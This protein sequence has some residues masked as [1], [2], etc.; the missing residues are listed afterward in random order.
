MRAGVS[1]ACLYPRL[2]EEALYDLALGGV[3]HTEIFIN[4]DC[5]CNRAFVAGLAET[6]SRFEMTCRAVHP[7]TC[8]M[9]PMMFFSNYPRRMN[10]I[11]EYYKRFFG[12]M[13]QLGAQIFVFHGNKSGMQ[14]PNALYFERYA[15]LVQLGKSFGVTVAQENVSRCES[16]SLRFLK[17]MAAALGD[18]AHFV[19]DTKQAVRA[20]ENIFDMVRA[21]GDHICH[22]HISDHGE[23]G[24]CLPIGKGRFQVKR[25]L[26]LLSEV[27][28][29]GSVMLELYRSNFDTISELVHNY[30]TLSRMLPEG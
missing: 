17:E 23:L 26:G 15:R 13:N 14:T 29:D 10:D 7:Y 6:L 1:T 5:E 11:L 2:L 19:L 12:V 22:V 28:F 18:D 21:L 4:T 24:D 16:G 27:G 30:H 20:K 9:E 3:S 8:P 25:F